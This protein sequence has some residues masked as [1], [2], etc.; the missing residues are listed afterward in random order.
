MEILPDLPGSSIVVLGLTKYVANAVEQLHKF[1]AMPQSLLD[2]DWEG[3]LAW[4]QRMWV[5]ISMRETACK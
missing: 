3:W 5:E 4:P 2:L 1:L